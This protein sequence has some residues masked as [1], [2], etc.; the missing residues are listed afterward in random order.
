MTSI[1]SLQTNGL[2]SSTDQMQRTRARAHARLHIQVMD[3][4][5]KRPLSVKR[6]RRRAVPCCA[7]ADI[8]AQ[9]PDI[10]RYA[11]NL[12]GGGGAW[13]R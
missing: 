1:K 13:R 9:A 11:A 4:V 6:R 8:R 5:A 7:L 3:E 12:I 2:I 10:R